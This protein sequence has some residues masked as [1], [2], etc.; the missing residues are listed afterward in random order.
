M[1]IRERKGDFIHVNDETV[2]SSGMEFTRTARILITKVYKYEISTALML[3]YNS[4]N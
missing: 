3:H 4:V 1:D 2:L